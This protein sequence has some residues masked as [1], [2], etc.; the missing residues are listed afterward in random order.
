MVSCLYFYF[1]NEN[2]HKSLKDR[3]HILRKEWIFPSPVPKYLYTAL[4][5]GSSQPTR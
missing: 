4:N 3:N 1:S 5:V 2:K